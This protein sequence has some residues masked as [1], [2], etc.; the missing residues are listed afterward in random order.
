MINIKEVAK[1]IRKTNNSY[2]LSMSPDIA[3]EFAEAL[4]ESYKAELQKE[5]GEPVN[6]CPVGVA[7]NAVSHVGAANY[8]HREREARRWIYEAE[9]QLYTSD[10]VAAAILKATKPLEDQLAAA[11]EEINSPPA[12]DAY[13]MYM[14]DDEESNP[15]ERLR[16][17]LSLALKDQD[18]IDVEKFI[19][20]VS[21]HIAKAEQRAAEACALTYLEDYDLTD[22]AERVRAGEYR[23]FMK[24]EQ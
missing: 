17:F 20:D 9:K 22:I 11:Q 14:A 3:A 1:R 10:Q 24:G 15:V 21:N 5:V 4:I 19:D 8:D 6:A 7:L 2:M 23:K 13:E 12:I 16:F 18:W